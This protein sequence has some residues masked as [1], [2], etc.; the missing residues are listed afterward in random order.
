MTLQ[1]QPS[2]PNFGMI[3][4]L[5]NH[6]P[7][8]DNELLQNVPIMLDS[9]GNVYLNSVLSALRNRSYNLD[10]IMI[11]YYSES[12]MVYVYCGRT[13]E[14]HENVVIPQQ[15]IMENK[16]IKLR[17]RHI[18]FD[19]SRSFL[20]TPQEEQKLEDHSR[21]TDQSYHPVEKHFPAHDAESFP[22]DFDE[23]KTLA[24]S[25]KADTP[26][27]GS[28]IKRITKDRSIGEVM[29]LIKQWRSLYN[30][31]EGQNGVKTHQPKTMTLQEAAVHIG[32]PKKTL[33]DYFLIIKK[34]RALNFD[35][36]ANRDER[37]GIVRSFVKK[38]KSKAKREQADEGKKKM[39][40]SSK[41]INK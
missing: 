15:D 18:D 28:R 27:S 16:V 5:I 37:F 41:K 4:V 14:I 2:G 11:Y 1:K 29:D 40:S 30:K 3:D 39:S 34:A 23:D 33:D 6:V 20:S 35:F 17:F 25:E 31:N 8:T 24:S 19:E 13:Y 9:K 36:N 7:E 21:H 32:V 38:N 22:T 12:N 26:R 10:R